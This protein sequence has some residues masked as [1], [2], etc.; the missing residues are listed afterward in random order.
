MR[1]VIRKASLLA[2]AETV[3]GAEYFL[4]EQESGRLS[5]FATA[6]RCLDNWKALLAK[7]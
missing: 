1:K 6:K 5:E 2:A 4:I 3:G 7:G